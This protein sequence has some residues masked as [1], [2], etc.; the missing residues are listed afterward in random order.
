MVTIKNKNEIAT[1]ELRKEVLDL[2]EAGLK[3][4]YPPELMR[5]VVG[6]SDKMNSLVVQNNTFDII[7]GRIFVIGGGKAAGLMAEVLEEIIGEEHIKAGVVNST[8]DGYITKKIK[9]IKA[10]RFYLGL[11]TCIY[12]HA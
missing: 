5:Q 9:I 4:V 12:R 11:L 8:S 10:D 1:S 6:Y 2:I 3:E 7:S